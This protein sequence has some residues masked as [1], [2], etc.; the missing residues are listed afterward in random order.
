MK[1]RLVFIAGNPANA[2]MR[3]DMNIRRMLPVCFALQMLV[4]LPILSA[5]PTAKAATKPA[6]KANSPRPKSESALLAEQLASPDKAA[7]DKALDRVKE[8]LADKAD[9]DDDRPRPKVKVN[10]NWLKSLMK[11]KRYDDAEA[12]ARTGI[13][14]Q[15][16][17]SGNIANFQKYVAQALLAEGKNE[18]ALSAAKGYYNVCPMKSSSDAIELIAV[19]LI[20]ARS[21]DRGIARKFKTQQVAAASATQPATAPDSM[22][23]D[24]VLGTI[25]ID[26]KPYDDAIANYAFKDYDNLLAK[27][28]LLLLADKPRDAR[29]CFETASDLAEGQKQ[30]SQAIESIARAIRAESGGIGPANVYI[31]KQQGN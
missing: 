4:G 6:A 20:N 3:M 7:Q 19:C 25:T 21:D 10:A 29:A 1:K 15:P 2:E 16:G 23:A 26:P 22:S 13:L 28:N 5:Q 24:N 12:L 11:V 18:Q 27:G 8:L 31:L 30:L 14:R 17:D 9:D